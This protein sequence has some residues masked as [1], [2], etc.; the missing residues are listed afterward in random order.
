MFLRLCDI[1]VR[2]TQICIE[3]QLQVWI[4]SDLLLPL[5]LGRASVCDEWQSIL[6]VLTVMYVSPQM[7]GGWYLV[8]LQSLV[9]VYSLW[10]STSSSWLSTT[11]YTEIK[12]SMR[13]FQSN[14]KT[15]ACHCEQIKIITREHTTTLYCHLINQQIIQTDDMVVQSYAVGFSRAGYSVFVACF[16]KYVKMSSLCFTTIWKYYITEDKLI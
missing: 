12:H 2:L 1:Y 3:A 13:L 4:F 6:F 10:C 9:L 7:N 16:V 8:I 5:Y 11:V 15:D 14:Q